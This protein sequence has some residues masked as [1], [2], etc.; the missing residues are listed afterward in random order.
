MKTPYLNQIIEL[1]ERINLTNNG[2]LF[3]PTD[4][5]I[6]LAKDNP[7]LFKYTLAQGNTHFPHKIEFK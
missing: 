6:K 4:T 7:N 1:V 5:E 2:Y 3:A